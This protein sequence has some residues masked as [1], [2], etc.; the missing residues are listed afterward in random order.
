MPG[1]ATADPLAERIRA[2][3]VLV[4]RAIRLLAMRHPEL[5]VPN[6]DIARREPLRERRLCVC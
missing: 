2:E 4:A 5:R 1:S 3:P 6:G